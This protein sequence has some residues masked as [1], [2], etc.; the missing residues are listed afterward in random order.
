M[1][2]VLYQQTDSFNIEI[3]VIDDGSTDKTVEAVSLLMHRHSN[4]KLIK[5]SN[6]GVSTARNRGMKEAHGNYIYF[7]DADDY[8]NLGAL[9]SIYEKAIDEG[10]DIVKFGWRY[11]A[12]EESPISIDPTAIKYRELTGS[13]YLI[14]TR[15]HGPDGAVWRMLMKRD[16]LEEHF[17]QFDEKIKIA[18]D[19]LFL[20]SI[21]PYVKKMIETDTVIYN[22]VQHPQSA[23]RHYL[24][25]SNWQTKRDAFI[26]LATAVKTLYKKA[27]EQIKNSEVSAVYEY[28]S[29]S[30]V[31]DAISIS[32]KNELQ[33]TDLCNLINQ[34]ES[35]GLYPI[36]P[37]SSYK[38]Y[39]YWGKAVIRIKWALYRRMLP[40]KMI[41]YLNS[42]INRLSL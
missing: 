37:L 16:F 42:H 5:Q 29:D 25:N 36:S 4:I 35:Q 20:L 8:L 26:K 13:G 7:F 17:S 31:Y 24:S 21:L 6:A 22:Y 39:E 18:E 23:M 27:Y 1:Q 12:P 32:I 3:I 40:L 15:A 38:K 34:L 30:C 2:S 10:A 28:T 19:N 41:C 9:Q 14:K 33:Y 11:A